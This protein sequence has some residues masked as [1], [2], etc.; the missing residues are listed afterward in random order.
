VNR[1]P[2]NVDVLLRY[3]FFVIFIV[4][5]NRPAPFV[6]EKSENVERQK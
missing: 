1:P 4:L 6:N 5:L 3:L 2:S